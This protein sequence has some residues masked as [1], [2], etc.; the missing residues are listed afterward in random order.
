MSGT[1]VEHSEPKKMTES[2]DTDRPQIISLSRWR[3]AALANLDGFRLA[4]HVGRIS[5]WLTGLAVSSRPEHCLLCKQSQIRTHGSCMNSKCYQQC[6][7][8]SQQLLHL[9]ETA[10]FSKHCWELFVVTSEMLNPL[11]WGNTVSKRKRVV[12][13]WKWI[14]K[15]RSRLHEEALESFVTLWT[16][17]AI[18]CLKAV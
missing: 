8:H 18:T 15:W 6:L 5:Q 10:E 2:T 7:I 17:A 11:Y 9:R 12:F 14:T 4:C 13:D 3:L 16:G 1:E